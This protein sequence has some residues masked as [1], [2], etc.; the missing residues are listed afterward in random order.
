MIILKMRKIKVFV[1]SG[2]AQIPSRHT[3]IEVDDDC[4]DQEINEEAVNS[5]LGMMSWGWEDID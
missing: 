2:Y 4:T 3:I 1:E 5:V